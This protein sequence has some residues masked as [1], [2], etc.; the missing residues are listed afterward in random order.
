MQEYFNFDNAGGLALH[1]YELP[2]HPAS[3]ACIRLLMRDAMWIHDWGDG[4]T[5]DQRGEIVERGTPLLIV[6]QYNFDAPPPWRS[7][8]HLSQG[9]HLPESTTPTQPIVHEVERRL[10]RVIASLT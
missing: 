2:G 1:A 9:I 5:I 8:E 6:G 4:W 10:R 7:P 3:H